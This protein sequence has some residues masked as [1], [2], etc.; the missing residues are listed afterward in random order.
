MRDRKSKL[1][2]PEPINLGKQYAGSKVSRDALEEDSDDDPFKARSS[3]EGED[4]DD[5]DVGLE[6]AEDDEDDSEGES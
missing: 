2:K 4:D 5:E 1:R 6:D 3:D